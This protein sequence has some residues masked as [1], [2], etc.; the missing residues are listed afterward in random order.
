MSTCRWHVAANRPSRQARLT[1][2]CGPSKIGKSWLVLWLGLCVAQGQPVW[3]NYP[4]RQS[5]VLYLCLEDNLPRVQR[6]L[7]KITAIRIPVILCLSRYEPSEEDFL[8]VEGERPE[9]ETLEGVTV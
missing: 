8:E 5:E 7:G 3:E 1:F 6:R 2:L 4:T 9:Q